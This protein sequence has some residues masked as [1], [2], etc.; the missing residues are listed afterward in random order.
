MTS[1]ESLLMIIPLVLEQRKFT[2][3]FSEAIKGL[4]FEELK[5][6]PDPRQSTVCNICLSV[7]VFEGVF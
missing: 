3:R 1:K 4:I 6:Y 2:F 5:V 7:S